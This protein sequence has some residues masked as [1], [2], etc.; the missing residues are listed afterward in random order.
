MTSRT[1]SPAVNPNIILLDVQGY[2]GLLDY[3]KICRLP[4]SEIVHVLETKGNYF[5]LA[6]SEIL[7][8]N[9]E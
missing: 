9:Y 6:F 5:S 8:N 2:Y 3:L 7:E 4:I 1:Y